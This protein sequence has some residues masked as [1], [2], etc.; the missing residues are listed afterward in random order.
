MIA[1]LVTALIIE[2]AYAVFTRTWLR[3]HLNG[4]E[5]EL[6]TSAVRLVTAG[7]Y[8]LMFRDVIMSRPA[9]ANALRRPLVLAGV[10]TV[11]VIPFLFRGW[12]PGGGLGTAVVFALTS[13]VVGL[14]E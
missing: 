14:R 8:W 1:K 10:A 2:I 6:A 5:L 13:I 12:S 4:V 7:A 9:R 11:L 3:A